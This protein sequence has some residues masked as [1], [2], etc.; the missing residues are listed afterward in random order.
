VYWLGMKKTFP[1]LYVCGKSLS[2]NVVD[3]LPDNYNFGWLGPIRIFRV[4]LSGI[5]KKRQTWVYYSDSPICIYNGILNSFWIRNA[6]LE[7][8]CGEVAGLSLS[9][10]ASV[11]NLPFPWKILACIY[12][13]LS[14]CLTT[15]LVPFSK[16]KANLALIPLEILEQKIPYQKST[17]FLYLPG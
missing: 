10:D 6:Y 11:S 8:M 9:K 4:G 3:R 15:L 5:F 12:L 16:N 2:S 1:L 14:A 7:K 17:P 13:F